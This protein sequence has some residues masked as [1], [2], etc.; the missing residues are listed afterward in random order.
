MIIAISASGSDGY[1]C[2]AVPETAEGRLNDK[3][4]TVVAPTEDFA[5]DIYTEEVMAED[6]Y[7]VWN[8]WANIMLFIFVI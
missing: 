6:Y 1:S 5:P 7:A 3:L 4:M 8:K 2:V